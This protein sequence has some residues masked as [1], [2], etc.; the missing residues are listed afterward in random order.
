MSLEQPRTLLEQLVAAGQHTWSEL[1][2]QFLQHSR[3]LHHESGEPMVSLS[4][5]H[6]QRIAAG[7]VIRPHPPT[8]RVLQRQFGRPISELLGPPEQQR[9]TWA[10][11]SDPLLTDHAD[12]QPPSE[13]NN[14]LSAGDLADVSFENGAL[15]SKLTELEEERSEQT[16]S[17]TESDQLKYTIGKVDVEVIQ[18][19]ASNFRR[20]DNRFGGGHTY[21]LIDNY[22]TSHIEPTIQSGRY[23]ASLRSAFFHSAAELYQLAGW[24]AYDIGDRVSGKR[25]LRIALKLCEET[26]NEGLAAEM[27]AGMSHQASF[28]RQDDSAVELAAAAGYVA[29]RVGIPKLRAEALVMEAHGL[30]LRGDHRGCIV[31]LQQAEKQFAASTVESPEWLSY[32]DEAYLSAKFGH[33]LRD[34]KRP[35]DAEQFARNALSMTGNGYERGKLFNTALLAGILADQGKVEESVQHAGAAVKMSN[36]IRSARTAAYLADVCERLL[37]YKDEKSVK[38]LYGAMDKLGLRTQSV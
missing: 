9:D 29:R 35:E 26:K 18:E 12:V 33:T 2:R 34:L 17:V 19:M 8:A 24:A 31:A 11:E 15:T 16:D 20:L 25:H 30:A 7:K 13:F 37:S 28:S 27:L 32:F 6:L 1:S 21:T 3:D 14:V 38:E 23:S 5:E 36:G 22:L 4:W 10:S